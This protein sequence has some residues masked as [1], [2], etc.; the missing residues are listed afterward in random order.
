MAVYVH[1]QEG[2][3]GSAVGGCCRRAQKGGSGTRHMMILTVA[4]ALLFAVASAQVMYSYVM[5]PSTLPESY[6]MFIVRTGPIPKD[7]L[8]A[9][10]HAADGMRIPVERLSTPRPTMLF[11]ILHIFF[12]AA[13]TSVK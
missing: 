13:T 7:I 2:A 3:A 1:R 12:F 11:F 5:R 8:E 4:Q 10:R 9:A 6:W